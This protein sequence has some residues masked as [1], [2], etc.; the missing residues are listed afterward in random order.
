M[1]EDWIDLTNYR[2]HPS[3]KGF[4]VFHFTKLDQADFFEIKLQESDLFYE[5]YNEEKGSHTVYYF[6]VKLKDMELVR[7]LNDVTIGK[8]RSPFIA[9][10]PVRWLIFAATLVILT[11]AIIGAIKNS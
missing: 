1:K 11:L 3:Q 4:Q 10:T 5:R 2:E 9:S 8:F 6:A 7:K